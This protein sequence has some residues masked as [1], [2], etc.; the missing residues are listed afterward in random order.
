MSVSLDEGS[1]NYCVH[2]ARYSPHRYLSLTALTQTKN[3]CRMEFRETGH[4]CFGNTPI[5]RLSLNY[6]I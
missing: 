4:W 1:Q 5:L 2:W 3:C 6:A